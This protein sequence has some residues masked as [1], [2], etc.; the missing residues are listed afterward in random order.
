MVRGPAGEVYRDVT[1]ATKVTDPVY[2]I[3]AGKGLS[4]PFAGQKRLSGHAISS[5]NAILS[6]CREI[7]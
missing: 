1:E 5:D 3:L 2:R 6:K 4:A 7:E